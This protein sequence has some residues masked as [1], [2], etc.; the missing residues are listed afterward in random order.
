MSAV[1]A[2]G[3][4]VSIGQSVVYTFRNTIAVPGDVKIGA[5]VN[6]TLLSL[7]AAINGTGAVGTDYFGG[8]STIWNVTA[9]T[10]SGNNMTLIATPGQAGNNI[11]TAESGANT[12]I[13]AFA[14]GLPPENIICYDTALTGN[15]IVTLPDQSIS[16][17]SNV[18]NGAWVRIVR[19]GAGAF[20]LTIKDGAGTTLDTLGSGV[21][22]VYEYRYRRG[23]WERT[24]KELW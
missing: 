5:S 9:G 16:V 13:T 14:G 11:S 23:K 17:D 21:T 10:I 4:T 18:F 1:P 2:D 6:A 19:S 7:K 20:S 12:S 22:G 15:R 8:T 24:S 3:D